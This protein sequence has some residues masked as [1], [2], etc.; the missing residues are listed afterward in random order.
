MRH[1]R[2]RLAN[3]KMSTEKSHCAPLFF[4]SLQSHLDVEMK[5]EQAGPGQ[6]QGLGYRFSFSSS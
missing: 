3:S 5:L 4:F 6:K 1:E 2:A